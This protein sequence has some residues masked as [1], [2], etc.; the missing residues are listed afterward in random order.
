MMFIMIL[1]IVQYRLFDDEYFTSNFWPVFRGTFLFNMYTWFI[2]LNIFIWDK[3]NVNYKVK[4]IQ[5]E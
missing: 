5:C 4:I 1:M 3:Y 2:A